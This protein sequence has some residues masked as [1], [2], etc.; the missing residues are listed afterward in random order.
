MT[1]PVS[2]VRK[3][4]A[5]SLADRYGISLKTI[6]RWTEAGILPRPMRVNRRRFWD[7]TELEAFDR[8]RL[9]PQTNSTAA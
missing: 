2:Q 3:L 1:I 6:D 8:S 4:T 9:D 7:A 5:R